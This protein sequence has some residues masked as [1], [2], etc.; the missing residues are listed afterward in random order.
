MGFSGGHI[1]W[2]LYLVLCVLNGVLFLASSTWLPWAVVPG[3]RGGL[4]AALCLTTLSW[5]L[6]SLFRCHDGRWHW[7]SYHGSLGRRAVRR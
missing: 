6:S 1:Y 4:W 2:A 5:G 3:R 7:I